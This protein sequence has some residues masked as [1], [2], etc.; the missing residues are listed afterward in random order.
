LEA[1]QPP[2]S[3]FFFFVTI[4]SYDVAS[5]FVDVVLEAF[6]CKYIENW[7]IKV[8]LFALFYSSSRRIKAWAAFSTF[9]CILYIVLNLY[10]KVTTISTRKKKR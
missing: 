8:F 5:V 3:F 1:V 7:S 2:T 6:I 10:I 4:D 9:S